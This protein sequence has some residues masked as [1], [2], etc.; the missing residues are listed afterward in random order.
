MMSIRRNLLVWLLGALA[1]IGVAASVWTYL[2]ANEDISELFDYQLQQIALSLRH[3]RILPQPQPADPEDQDDLGDFITQIRSPDGKL[4]YASDPKVRLPHY[5]QQG[6]QTRR[7]QGV[8][9]RIFV[10]ATSE[11]SVLVAQPVEARR[12]VAAEVALRIL[13]PVLVLI[14]FLG[15]VIR[16]GVLRGLKPLDA[17]GDALARRTPADLIPVS[18]AGLPRELMP[19]VSQLNDLLARLGRA[20]EL[21]RQFVGDA[22]H[23]LRTP[24][25]AV[26]LQLQVLERAETDEERRS[27][28]ERLGAGVV[29]ATR[30]VE[31]L[32]ALARAEPD[33]AATGMTV[34]QLERVI[35]RVVAE[36]A[37]LALD[38]GVDLGITRLEPV[39]VWGDEESLRVMAG[40]LVGNAIN[41]TPAG[42]RAD[43]QVFAAGGQ[44]ALEVED[45]GPGIA[46]DM[47]ARV[48][49]RFHR[50]AGSNG[51]GSGLGLAIVRAIVGRHGGTVVL[52]DGRDGR[53][54]RVSVRLPRITPEPEA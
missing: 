46:A 42:G 11:R 36:W 32:L 10:T 22:A 51:S 18:A 49:D 24:L 27:A 44:A 4:L 38:Q 48:F 2:E 53:G 7:W 50:G 37:E 23:E 26:Q 12:A 34:V 31:Q 40:N 25:T 47:R 54:L 17:I 3:H 28:L 35:Q 52:D 33:G 19:M 21:Q 15:L 1:L 39:T 14:P 45:N 6:L 41:Y 29:R 8:S 13:V 20:M 16:Y 30:L 9:Y 5:A 43:V